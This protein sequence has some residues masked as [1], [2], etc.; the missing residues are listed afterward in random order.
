MINLSEFSKFFIANWKLNG[1]LSFIKEYTQ[2]LKVNSS[3]GN[4]VVICPTAIYLNNFKLNEGNYY[5]GAQ[6]ISK[7]ETGA[8][9]GE[10]SSKSLNE[11]GVNFCIV[12]HSERRQH[13]NEKN[14]DVKEKATKLL[15]NEII[16]IVC[17]GETLEEKKNNS[18]LDVISNQIL[19]G[20]PSE[21]NEQ[22]TIIAYEPIWAI[23]TGLTPS[24]EE[25]DIIHKSIR[26]IN[27]KINNYKIVYGGSVNAK[28]SH[29]II[30]L[31]DVDGALIGGASLKIDDFNKIIG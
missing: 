2:L 6:D 12:G 7:Y 23:G 28:N 16:P 19:K 15:E 21:S 3:N 4:C 13:F 29:D 10:I 30:N 9:T 17:V 25:I 11:F 31:S 8:F 1:N 5:L 22:N 14:E 27:N 20:I 24:I 18:T 26:K